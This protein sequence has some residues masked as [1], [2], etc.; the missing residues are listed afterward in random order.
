WEAVA[1][2]LLRL[3][4]FLAAAGYVHLTCVYARATLGLTR[5]GN[6][7]QA[8]ATGAGFVT[9]RPFRTLL[10][11]ALYGVTSLLPLAIWGLFAPVCTGG[12]AASL[13]LFVARQEL[14]VALR[15]AARTA[16]LGAASAWLRRVRE[17]S[18]PVLPLSREV[19]K[20]ETQ[21]AVDVPAPTSPPPAETSPPP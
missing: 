19:P 21:R 11:A 2:A 16:P 15:I 13:V 4:A 14:L 17:A 18:R 10:L 1:L 20:I 5:N 9:G 3:L 8:L 6:P 7:F 12:A